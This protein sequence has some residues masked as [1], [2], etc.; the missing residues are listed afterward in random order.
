MMATRGVLACVLALA[1]AAPRPGPAA[2]YVIRT[3]D[4][5]ATLEF[6]SRVLG[7]IVLRHEEN[8]EACPITCNGDYAVPW[9]K[10]M[11]GTAAED[12]AYALEITYNYGVDGYERGAALHKFEVYVADVEAAGAAAV[13]LG[14]VVLGNGVV[15]PDGY[16]FKLRPAPEGRREPFKAVRFEVADPE[17]T[18]AWYGDAL[19]MSARPHGTGQT[20]FFADD[21]KE[22]VVF[23]FHR[24]DAHA[25][26]QYDGRN[27]FSL[28]ATQVR[29]VY[30][31]LAREEPD[32]VVHDLQ[33]INEETG[34]GVLLI[35]IV[36]DVNGLELCLV[37]S[38]AFEPAIKGA[39]DGVGPD[40]DERAK[41][42][43]DYAAKVAAAKADKPAA[44]GWAPE[45]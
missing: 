3:S 12:E 21:E 1:G 38:E 27:A 19:G 37:S 20:V 23:E 11:V 34:L 9:S 13:A 5:R 43:T 22:G 36:T 18:A 15:G 31:K 28:P 8:P 16:N 10:T 30:E 14:Y 7:L 4:L 24:G 45:L 41:L 40:Y 42:A 35:A 2:H 32:R 6:T 26:T 33:E 17:A 39:F 44:F 25:I 29:A